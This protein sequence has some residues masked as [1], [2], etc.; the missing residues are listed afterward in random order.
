MANLTLEARGEGIPFLNG[1]VGGRVVCLAD[2]SRG[3]VAI[4][5]RVIKKNRECG[6]GSCGGQRYTCNRDR[7]VNAQSI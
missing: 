7:A 5:D 3:W 1:D 2:F 4:I 6:L